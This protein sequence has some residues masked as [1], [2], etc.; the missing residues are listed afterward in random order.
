ME[1]RDNKAS[2]LITSVP[3]EAKGGIFALQQVLYGNLA[4]K[5]SGMI[6]FPIAS[7]R[8]FEERL[9]SRLIRTLARANG[10]FWL[11][12]K[13]R[14]IR[15]V[16][17]NTAYDPKALLR[18]SLFLLASKLCGKKVVLQIHQQIRSVNKRLAVW[19]T[20][21]I[22]SLSDRILVFSKESRTNLASMVPAEKI[23]IFPNAVR[24]KDFLSEDRTFKKA[25]SIPDHGKVVLFLA[26]LLKEKG[27]YDVIASIPMIAANFRDVYFVFAGD[28][29][30]RQGMEARCKQNSVEERVRFTGH[31][32]Y[33]D[34]IRAYA[35]SDIFLFPTYYSEGMPMVVL[36]ALAAGLP[37]ISGAAGAIPD[38][39]QDEVNGFLVE[40]RSPK[41]IVEKALLLL[42]DEALR[43]RMRDANRELAMRDFDRDTITKKLE[44]LY[45]SL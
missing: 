34:V 20:R 35:C 28:G 42:T 23:Q 17:I 14:T 9:T 38:I 15:V 44:A 29:P 33:H 1:H 24:V 12:L 3:A 26:R 43:K 11:L 2:I 40:P 5:R 36:Q 22:F 45:A 16:H 27:V 13:D 6:L 41:Q 25:L 39:V 32:P 7:R 8:P 30:E 4:E 37:I 10:F 31:I 19:I 18:D 21:H